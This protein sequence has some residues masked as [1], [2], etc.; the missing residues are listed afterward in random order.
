MNLGKLNEECPK[1][2]SK[3]KTLNRKLDAQH[4]AFG[5]SQSLVCS[6]C[7][8]VFKSKDETDTE[9]EWFKKEYNPITKIRII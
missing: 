6:E 9:S 7:G 1:C 8:Y 5:T 2:G 4:R 3:D